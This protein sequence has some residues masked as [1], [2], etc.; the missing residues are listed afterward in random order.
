MLR[1]DA[2]RAAQ[3]EGGPWTSAYRSESLSYRASWILRSEMSCFHCCASERTASIACARVR[4]LAQGEQ[5][6]DCAQPI[7]WG[8]WAISAVV[9]LRLAILVGVEIALD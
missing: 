5:G 9:F 7:G 8:I 6:H 3:D 2:L 1:S 4:R